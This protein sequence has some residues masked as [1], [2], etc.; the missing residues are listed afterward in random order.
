MNHHFEENGGFS[1]LAPAGVGHGLE[2][3]VGGCQANRLLLF[4]TRAV[5]GGG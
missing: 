5:K 2:E 1:R 4:V 3:G